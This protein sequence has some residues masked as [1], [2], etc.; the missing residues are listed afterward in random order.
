M[1]QKRTCIPH[2]RRLPKDFNDECLVQMHVVG[3]L[4]YNET[5]KPHVF[6]T[7][8]NL[9]ND[10]NLIVTVIQ[11]VLMTWGKPLPPV[12]YIQLDNTAREDKNST[13]FGY[14][15]WTKEFL[16]K[17]KLTS[18]WLVTHITISFR[19]STRSQGSYHDMMLPRYQSYW[20]S[21]VMHIHHIQMYNTWRRYMT[22]RD[23]S[24]MVGR[25]MSKF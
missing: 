8:P 12:L 19:C 5:I 14:L 23:T 15:R 4:T 13:I 21:F 7:Y 3:C 18:Y 9:H 1:N 22:S 6:V 11:R 24:Q 16:G 2:L 20:T 17:W 10:P 25:E